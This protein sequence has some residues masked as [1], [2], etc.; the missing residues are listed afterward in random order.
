MQFQTF[1]ALIVMFLRR[2]KE[3]APGG[4]EIYGKRMLVNGMAKENL[5]GRTTVVQECQTEAERIHALKSWFGI[6]LSDE[7]IDSIRGWHTELKATELT[8]ALPEWAPR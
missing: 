8:D 5:G 1:T 2:P 7:E 6:S 3:D 4:V